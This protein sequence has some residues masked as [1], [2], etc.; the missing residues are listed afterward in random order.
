MGER[1][2]GK[3]AVVTGAGRGIGREIALL[4]AAE[5]ARVVV[6]DLGAAIDGTG[7]SRTPADETVAEIKRRGGEAVANY[8]SVVDF[9]GSQMIIQTCL[10]SFGRI[11]I[12]V[13][14]AGNLRTSQI[15][16]T[17]E[18]DWDAVI[19]VHLYGTFNT[20]RHAA[21]LMKQQRYGR[22]INTTSSAWLGSPV[23]APYSAAKAGVVALTRTLAGELGRYGVTCNCYAPVALS[24]M[25]DS[26]E[27][28]K[29]VRGRIEAGLYTQQAYQ[30]LPGKAPPS[31]VAP[32]I[33]YL[34]TDHAAG[35]NGCVFGCGGGTVTL[36][37]EP[38]EFRGIFKDYK[39]DGAWTLD[40]L[41]ILVP[42]P[43]MVGY[44][45]PAPQ[46]EKQ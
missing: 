41:A 13:N 3:N 29:M 37:S 18:E 9:R 23:N 45:N 38:V 14:V 26:E 27:V 16:A 31:F 19:K 5:G 6:N 40:E 32:T 39:K 8:E 28:R 35:I 1:L 17:T 34:A 12:L 24:R 46:G 42:K 30:D 2:K 44:V 22:I 4:M 21:P 33:A 20:C 43:L 10:D 11:D 7:A 25:D 15:T 36:Y